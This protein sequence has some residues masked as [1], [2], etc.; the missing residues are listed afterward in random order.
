MLV[1]VPASKNMALSIFLNQL[2]ELVLGCT[3]QL[4]NLLVVLPH[5]EG[6]HSADA[7]LLGNS[8]QTEPNG[9]PCAQVSYCRAVFTC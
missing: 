1:F 3:N 7:T 2:V 8:L 9:E 6:W 5:L 4:I